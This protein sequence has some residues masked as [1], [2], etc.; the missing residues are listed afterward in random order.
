MTTIYFKS[1]DEKTVLSLRG[2][3]PKP[4]IA[5]QEYIQITQIEFRRIKARIHKHSIS[6]EKAQGLVEYALLL[7]LIALFVIAV[8]LLLGPIIGN[9][10]TSINS[11]LGQ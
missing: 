10:F 1:P 7:V 4:G 5:P 2:K 3:D 9:I 11:S 8:L 6:S